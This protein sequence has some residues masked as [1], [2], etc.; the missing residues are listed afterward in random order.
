[1]P[2]IN[3]VTGYA[4]L[5]TRNTFKGGH[6]QEFTSI[7]TD[8]AILISFFN[9]GQ[10]VFVIQNAETS[11]N[12][13]TADASGNF[14]ISNISATQSIEAPYFQANIPTGAPANQ[15]A[16][17]VW[18]TDASTF[19]FNIAA[20]GSILPYNNAKVALQ[21]RAIAGQTAN[22]FEVQDASGN[23]YSGFGPAGRAGIKFPVSTTTSL[24]VGIAATA[25]IGLIVKPLT[26][27]VTNKALTSNVATLTTSINHNLVVGQTIKVSGVNATFNGSYV[28]TAVT[29]NTVSYA[30]TAANVTSSSA[31]GTVA[32][33][34]TSNTFELWDDSGAAIL[35]ISQNGTINHAVSANLNGQS[36]VLLS[37]QGV[38]RLM[39]SGSGETVISANGGAV[40]NSVLTVISHTSLPSW[41]SLITKGVNTQSGN[42][43]EARDNNDVIL[44]TVSENGYY[45]TRKN[46]APADA[47][48]AN[49]EAAYWFDSTNGAA[50][51][52]VK[53]K[54]ADGTVVT[55]SLA[56]A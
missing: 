53:A 42:L 2:T 9:N 51:F 21:A 27:S 6:Q 46:A 18:N 16:I 8:P 54:Q 24:T 35:S 55:G 32:L 48:L 39:C 43:F 7:D 15:S 14:V 50:K 22:I 33:T 13:L 23:F 38:R 49:G 30:K 29:A 56:L 36:G 12:I 34:T 10:N 3:I 5:D 19:V 25:D 45:T 17:A 41:V 47:E 44:S 28:I 4:K 52:M 11:E 31:T 40:A 26:Y 1:M 37:Y 20:D